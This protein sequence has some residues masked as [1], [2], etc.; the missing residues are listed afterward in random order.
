MLYTLSE[1]M[2]KLKEDLEITDLPLPVTDA[3][4]IKRFA[5]SALKEFSVRSP[6]IVDFALSSTDVVN[7]KSIGI[8]GSAT[9]RIPKSVYQDR[10]IIEVLSIDVG[11]SGG[12]SDYYVPTGAFNDPFFMLETMADIQM[13]AQLGSMMQHAPTFRF[14]SPDLLRIYNGWVGG[15]YQVE[16]SMTHDISLT[17][18]PPGAFTHLFQLAELDMGAY[19]YGKLKRKDKIDTGSG[20]ETDLKIDRW[21]NSKQEMRDLLKQWDDEGVNFDIDPINYW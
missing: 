12:F 15:T 17:T 2:T 18:I 19:L 3:D 21:E 4:M 8:D 10:S 20:S 5:N 7:D 6:L 16:L 14:T 13:G 1:F 9:Y 11:R